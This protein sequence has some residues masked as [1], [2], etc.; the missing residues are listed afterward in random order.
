MDRIQEDRVH[1][2]A[3]RTFFEDAWSMPQESPVSPAQATL[4]TDE[5]DA[6]NRRAHD[7]THEDPTDPSP[8]LAQTV[9]HATRASRARHPNA[10]SSRSSSRARSNPP[11]S[12]A[13]STRPPSLTSR[14]LPPSRGSS[15]TPSRAPPSL[16]PSRTSTPA[17]SAG[18]PTQLPSHTGLG[19][20][21][22]QLAV[23][24]GTSAV[25]AMSGDLHYSQD[26]SRMSTASW[27]YSQPP[28]HGP[29][30]RMERFG[31]AS[32]LE[33]RLPSPS[34]GHLPGPSQLLRAGSE[35]HEDEGWSQQYELSQGEAQGSGGYDTMLVT[36]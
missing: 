15:H 7:M 10:T 12:S 6:P 9:H 30:S 19:S 2:P 14:T 34:S 24:P 23:A 8:L 3:R 26:T 36:D 13:A 4:P 33:W 31:S 27:T 18:G 28:T 32:E 25:S 20:F 21:G 5:P 35:E 22:S 17:W 1:Y 16:V 29:A 11:S